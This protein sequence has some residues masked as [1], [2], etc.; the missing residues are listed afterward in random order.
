[1][2]IGPWRIGGAA[3]LA[4]LFS[5]GEEQTLSECAL[6][7]RKKRSHLGG[8]CEGTESPEER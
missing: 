5:L 4:H 3:R 8:D 2:F 6:F 7:P 1:M